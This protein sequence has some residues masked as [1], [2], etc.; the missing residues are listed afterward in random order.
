MEHATIFEQPTTRTCVKTR[1]FQ[2]SIANPRVCCCTQGLCPKEGNNPA[3]QKESIVSF[4]VFLFFIRLS[5]GDPPLSSPP[6]RAK[7]FFEPCDNGLYVS[8]DDRGTNWLTCHWSRERLEE[9]EMVGSS[10]VS[11]SMGSMLSSNVHPL[12]RSPR[13]Q[14]TQEQRVL[15]N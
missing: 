7:Y 13:A 4:G 12:F 2:V 6:P 9:R 3:P 11:S 8:T 5:K 14:P 1:P 10:I 15:W